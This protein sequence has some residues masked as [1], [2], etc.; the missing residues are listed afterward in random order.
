MIDEKDLEIIYEFVNNYEV[1]NK[2]I[3]INF[4]NKI[5]IVNLTAFA[6]ESDYDEISAISFIFKDISL[7]VREKEEIINSLY[8]EPITKLQNRSFID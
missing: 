4:Q 7:V 1:Y 2:T 8:I 6:L 5:Y 3:N